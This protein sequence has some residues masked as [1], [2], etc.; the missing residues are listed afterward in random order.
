M[1]MADRAGARFALILGDR[2]AESGSVTVRRLEDGHEDA[3]PITDVAAWLSRQ[4]SS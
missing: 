3:V 1:K 2:E 4:E